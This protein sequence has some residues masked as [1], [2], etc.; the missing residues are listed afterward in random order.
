LSTLPKARSVLAGE[1]R[2]FP[3]RAIKEC[4]MNARE[5]QFK[6]ADLYVSAGFK[7]WWEFSIGTNEK[8]RWRIDLLAIRP[9]DGKHIAIECDRKT[10]RIKSVEKLS[11]LPNTYKKIIYLRESSAKYFIDDIEVRGCQ[12]EN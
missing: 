4:E 11:S 2:N 1:D 10:P 6:V 5:F 12:N 3:G 7:V 8:R 9:G